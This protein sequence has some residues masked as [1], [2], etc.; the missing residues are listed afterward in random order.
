MPRD[1][2]RTE[3]A[4]AARLA[5]RLAWLGAGLG[6]LGALLVYAPAR[7]LASALAQASGERV[8]LVNAQGTV[9]Q[10]RAELVLTGGAGSRDATAL[11]QGLAWRL[12]PAWQGGPA[13]RA[14]LDAPCCMAQPVALTL[15]AL[16]GGGALHWPA[17]QS[18]WPTAL[19]AGL[20]TPWNT[21]QLDGQ[22]RLDNG[23][24]AL[25][26]QQGRLALG[27]GLDVD[28]LSLAS[29]LSTLRPLGSY[30]L[31][32]Q[33]ADNPQDGG[34]SGARLQLSTLD[35]ALR[36]SGEGQWVGGRLRFNGEAEAREDAEAALSNL[37]NI[38]GKRSGRRSRIA[39]G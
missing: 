9:W 4:L 25:R 5:R 7:W 30:R 36:L 6:V 20:G 1:A 39:L 35:G 29:R 14:T 26:W 38:V 34:Q 19:L 18:Q 3:P 15:R 23:G 16:W 33:A 24:L 32:L 10:G 31:R 17:H 28:A 13:L 27:G 12:A 11:P 8:R 37:L 22:L 21:L 2:T